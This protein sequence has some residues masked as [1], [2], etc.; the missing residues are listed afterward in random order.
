MRFCNI[1]Q[2]KALDTVIISNLIPL[3]LHASVNSLITSP[4]APIHGDR[5]SHTVVAVLG[6][7][8][9]DNIIRKQFTIPYFLTLPVPLP[10]PSFMVSCQTNLSRS[11]GHN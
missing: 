4:L 11:L 7:P 9:A 1:R 3:S 5:G 8:Q 6:W 10:E 2:V